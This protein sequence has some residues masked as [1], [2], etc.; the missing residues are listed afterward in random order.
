MAVC[1]QV[2]CTL[3]ESLC[4]LVGLDVDLSITTAAADALAAADLLLAAGRG[5]S[6]GATSWQYV[7]APLLTVMSLVR[8]DAAGV[9]VMGSAGVKLAWPRA[10]VRE[11]GA[12]GQDAAAY[13]QIPTHLLHQGYIV[14]WPDWNTRASGVRETGSV[15]AAWRGAMQTACVC[16]AGRVRSQQRLR[17][18][19]APHLARNIARPCFAR[20]EHLMRQS[21]GAGARSARHQQARGR[22]GRQP[23]AAEPRRERRT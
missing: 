11:G 14:T 1:V 9:G 4:D 6:G 19:R 2:L 18:R 7:P 13:R 15:T 8:R 22:E 23:A 17:A 3:Q 21:V 12:E 16:V 20:F 10:Q 5:G